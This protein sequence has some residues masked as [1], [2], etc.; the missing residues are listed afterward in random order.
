VPVGNLQ[1]KDLFLLE[2]VGLPTVVGFVERIPE[3]KGYVTVVTLGETKHRAFTDRDGEAH[4]FDGSGFRR[5]EW[6]AGTLVRPLMNE[7]EMAEMVQ[8]SLVDSGSP[9]SSDIRAR[10]EKL[11][12][13]AASVKVAVPQKSAKGNVLPGKAKAE[14]VA[15]APKAPREQKACRCGCGGTTG[16]T[17]CPGHDARYYGW[18]KAI[19]AGSKEFKE[20][21]GHLRKEFVDI[22]GVK[23]ALAASNH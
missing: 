2:A 18:L 1:P 15:K 7:V 23:R 8:S 14:K 20:L 10:V 17:F 19:S 9:S 12:A 4:E 21:P 6:S 3:A 22:K 11:K 13:K 5:V 16:G